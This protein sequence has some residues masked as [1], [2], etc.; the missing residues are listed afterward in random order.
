M[1]ALLL[2]TPVADN[3]GARRD[4]GQTVEVGNS[5]DQITLARA[6]ALVSAC[7]AVDVE[8]P[9]KRR[10]KVDPDSSSDEAE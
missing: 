2:Q 5:P 1:K 6:K 7:S 9:A 8:P 3:G 4:A 10:G